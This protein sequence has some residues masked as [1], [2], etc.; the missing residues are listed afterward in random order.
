MESHILSDYE[1]ARRLHKELNGYDVEPPQSSKKANSESIVLSDED[2]AEVSAVPAQTSKAVSS[3]RARSRS[4]L[5]VQRQVSIENQ[6]AIT[7]SNP[8]RSSRQETIK[9]LINFRFKESASLTGTTS[10]R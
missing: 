8:K 4:P 9:S 1:L 6:Q 5:D 10:C 7:V 2:L 3:K